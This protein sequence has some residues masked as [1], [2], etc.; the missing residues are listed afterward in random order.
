MSQNAVIYQNNGEVSHAEM[1]Y[2]VH[3]PLSNYNFIKHPVTPAAGIQR[4]RGKCR[5]K[6]TRNSTELKYQFF[7]DL[8]IKIRNGG[9]SLPKSQVKHT[10]FRNRFSPESKISRNVSPQFNSLNWQKLALTF[11]DEHHEPTPKAKGQVPRS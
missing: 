8:S 2:S 4:K 7:S 3:S 10:C 1:K 5:L 11:P 6:N 9:I